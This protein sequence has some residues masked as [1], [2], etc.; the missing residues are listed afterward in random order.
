MLSII[1]DIPSDVIVTEAITFN[2]AR[3]E[4]RCLAE[5]FSTITIDGFSWKFSNSSRGVARGLHWQNMESPQEKIIYVSEGKIL[6]ILL[7]MDPKSKNYGTC[8]RFSISHEFGNV[9]KIPSNY[10][11]GFIALTD[12]QFM[13]LCF[14]KYD[15]KKEH[16]INM[17]DYLP[18]TI[19]LDTLIMSEKDKKST[20]FKRENV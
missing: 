17:T 13:Y 3:G 12:V 10:A 19:N 9:F 1:D 5:S 20:K 4:L 6:D 14:G 7:D 16:V 11:H 15:E 8:Y 2:D 18:K